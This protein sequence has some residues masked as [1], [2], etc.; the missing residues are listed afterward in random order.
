MTDLEAAK[1]AINRI[2]SDKSVPAERTASRLQALADEIEV[3]LDTLPPPD[4]GG[5]DDEGE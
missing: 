1:A 5:E 4:D 2:F 3:M